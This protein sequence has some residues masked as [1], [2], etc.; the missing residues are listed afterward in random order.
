[1]RLAAC[2][3]HFEPMIIP[4]CIT[5]WLVSSKIWVS[6]APLFIARVWGI[7]AALDV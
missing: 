7:V 2:R 1:M 3:L 5:E 6:L 4:T